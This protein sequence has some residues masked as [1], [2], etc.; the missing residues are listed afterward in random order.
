MFGYQNH[1]YH[2]SAFQA[3]NTCRLQKVAGSPQVQAHTVSLPPTPNTRALLWSSTLFAMH[4]K[5][6]SLSHFLPP[7]FYLVALTF[8]G[9]C[10]SSGV[11]QIP[12]FSNSL[13]KCSTCTFTE[14]WRVDLTFKP[15]AHSFWVKGWAD[16]SHFVDKYF[17]VF[18]ASS[19]HHS[20]C[21][22]PAYKISGMILRDILKNR[23][24]WYLLT[25][26]PK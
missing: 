7:Q 4:F 16:R 8:H 1:N 21:L 12:A 15:T 23:P 6:E 17:C 14:R 20:H 18:P 25:Y 19:G 26:R 2:P 13:H 11:S 24:W 9:S 10:P 3:E 22:L 5:D